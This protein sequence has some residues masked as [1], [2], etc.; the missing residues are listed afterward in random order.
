MAT[1]LTSVVR[2]IGQ[3]CQ[4][5]AL[6]ELPR[7]SKGHRTRRRGLPMLCL[8]RGGETS[9][10]SVLRASIERALATAEPFRV[11]HAVL[12]LDPGESR[13]PAEEKDVLLP[14]TAD[15]VPAVRTML[16]DLATGLKRGGAKYGRIRFARFGLIT[17]LM[18]QRR[19]V[20]QSPDADRWLR[21]R[22]RAY[23]TERIQG[24][25]ALL[26]EAPLDG[27]LAV[28]RW[29][30]TVALVVGLW[31]RRS[32]RPLIGG[33]YRWLVRRQPYLTPRDPGTFLGFAERLTGNE[34][35]RQDP[36]QVARLLVHA[37][38]EDLRRAFGPRRWPWRWRGPRRMSY[39]VVFLDG[40]SRYNGGYQL[41][42][43]INDVRTETGQFDPLLVI[44]ASER[45]PPYARRAS[46][47]SGAGRAADDVYRDW[48]DRFVDASRAGAP[49]AWYLP[50]DVEPSP[51]PTV[52]LT[53]AAPPWWS[54]RGVPVVLG[55]LVAAAALFPVVQW[56]AG[57]CDE[58]PYQQ[59]AQTLRSLGGEC[60]G[61][62]DG[63]RAFQPGNTG[64]SAVER[65]IGAQN[66]EAAADHQAQP[67]RPYAQLVY[68]G[69]L[70][71]NAVP[72]DQLVAQREELEGVAALQRRQLDLSGTTDPI[73]RVLLANAG[74]RLRYAQQVSSIIRAM[75]ARDPS[76]IGVVGFNQSHR[77]IDTVIKQLNGVGLPMVAATLSADSIP[78]LS[79]LYFQVSPLNTRE[80]AVAA[81]FTPALVPTARRAL[82]LY[83]D[84][85]ADLYATS[86]AADATRSLRTRG[87]PT[88]V[89][90]FDPADPGGA[91]A[92]TCGYRGLVFY[93]GRSDAFSGFLNGIN[94]QCRDTAPTILADDDVSHYVADTAQRTRYP[95]IPF[96]Y[97]S[98]A[99]GSSPCASGNG[100]SAEVYQTIRRVFPFEC[101]RGTRQDVARDGHALLAYDAAWSL[102]VA[103]QHVAGAGIPLSPGTV[104]Q[105]LSHITLDGESG[106]I[107]FGSG[108][109]P[110]VPPDKAVAI[111]RVE[112]STVH[113]TPYVCGLLPGNTKPHP[114]C[115][116]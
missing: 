7:T 12:D 14:V 79:P 2:L 113:E 29:L 111:L 10:R 91:G 57:H 5:P 39:L 8:V 77:P 25:K 19:D 109:Q 88:D 103:A 58:W 67:G 31:L 84:D 72:T 101:R 76:I 93:A 28:V 116:H 80:A 37:F 94:Q 13:P 110:H 27:R 51:A 71:S 34:V 32:G 92:S 68:L 1:D 9:F 99:I 87:Y 105:E 108:E 48:R 95:S 78:G 50:L 6:G 85:P 52:T 61:I 74:T 114:D 18:E 46:D 49:T 47:D 81:A 83:P 41:L 55:C 33:G 70:S 40:I 56:R 75:S 62:S 53:I 112:H 66:A 64:L 38:L 35:G 106:R 63:S 104:W 89:R 60:V 90:A 24:G 59:V 20:S 44:T 100:P 30:V 43:L 65:A 36:D 96:Y 16:A 86:L 26:D 22:L 98:F 23:Q 15:D 69:V 45:V 102:T 17:W 73:I 115:P 4:R 21:I 97:V 42:K 11:P 107:A 54:R 82:V 3:L